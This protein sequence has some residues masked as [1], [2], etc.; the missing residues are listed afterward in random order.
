[1]ENKR[2]ESMRTEAR[3]AI[4]N[5]LK[6]GYTGYY[7]D[8]HNKVFNME[9][10]TDSEE[11]SREILDEIDPYYAIGMNVKYE[12][13]NFGVVSYEKYSNPIWV[14]SMVWY[15]IGEEELWKM[16]ENCEI[17]DDLYNEIATKETEE[18]LID[19]LERNERI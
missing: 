8:L 10:Y 6:E 16:F 5:C 13:E 17:W 18:K 15:I 12:T 11:E 19:W 2:I 1:M 7:C 9:N 3:E 14:L 4:I